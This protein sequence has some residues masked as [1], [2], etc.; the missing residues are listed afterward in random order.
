M[1]VA[2]VKAHNLKLDCWVCATFDEARELVSLAYEAY[3]GEPSYGVW[4]E[5]GMLND[6]DFVSH[7]PNDFQAA[8]LSRKPCASGS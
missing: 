6:Y 8:I 1:Y 5:R 7:E 2:V 4:V 3:T